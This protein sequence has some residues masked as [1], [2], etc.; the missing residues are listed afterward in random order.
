QP[1]ETLFRVCQVWRLCLKT[2]H[3]AKEGSMLTDSQE[4]SSIH[5][6]V[7]LCSVPAERSQVFGDEHL[8]AAFSVK[9]MFTLKGNCSQIVK[10]AHLRRW[11]I[12]QVVAN[13]R[14]KFRN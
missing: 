3:A 8:D 7:T 10:Q 4:I 1:K 2:K 12:V 5:Q 9:K 11:V 14:G 6:L 13:S